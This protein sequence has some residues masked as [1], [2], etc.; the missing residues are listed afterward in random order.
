M[1]RTIRLILEMAITGI[2][3]T[4][5]LGYLFWGG[6]SGEKGIWGRMQAVEVPEYDCPDVQISRTAAG[7]ISEEIPA[8][9]LKEESCSPNKSYLV[10]ELFGNSSQKNVYMELVEVYLGKEQVLARGN[11]QSLMREENAA[12]ALYEE[13][14]GTLL[15]TKQGNYQLELIV[16]TQYGRKP[17]RRIR[18]TVPVIS[19]AKLKE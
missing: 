2:F 8:V 19:G 7:I 18:V 1:E 6:I 16:G 9:W 11:I 15:F 5:L 4:F 14:S 13:K 12:A 3:I 17:C 10:Q